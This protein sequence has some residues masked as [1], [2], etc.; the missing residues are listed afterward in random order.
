MS[1]SVVVDSKLN[2][3]TSKTGSAE[4]WIRLS[5]IQVFSTGKILSRFTVSSEEFSSSWTNKN[6]LTPQLPWAYCKI[7]INIRAG[8]GQKEGGKAIVV[9]CRFHFQRYDLV[10]FPNQQRPEQSRNFQKATRTLVLGFTRPQWTIDGLLRLLT[11][12]QNRR[13]G[14]DIYQFRLK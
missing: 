7:P 9:L 11:A 1:S 13:R 2:K 6:K 8:S 10:V 4:F 14:L 5:W 12:K 3:K